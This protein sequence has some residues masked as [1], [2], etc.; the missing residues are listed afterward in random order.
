M[1]QV[2]AESAKA[3]HDAMLS[4][5]EALSAS[6]AAAQ[7]ADFLAAQVDPSDA[8]QKEK[9]G[10][11]LRFCFWQSGCTKVKSANSGKS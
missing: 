5:E 3:S 8:I 11:F 9:R 4:A 10:G 1:A 2:A 7:A 6:D